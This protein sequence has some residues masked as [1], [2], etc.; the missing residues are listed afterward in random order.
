MLQ[1]LK[2]ADVPPATVSPAATVCEAIEEMVRRRVGAVAVVE[3][4]K[5]AGIFTERDVMIRVVLEGRNPD[6]TPVREVMT[7]SVTTATTEITPG[8][9]LSLMIE[10]HFRHLPI[11]DENGRVAGML[12]IRNVLESRLEDVTRE[13]DSLGIYLTADGPGG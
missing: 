7:A 12:S 9:A 4:D 11:L 10:H 8:E 2:L 1:I 13:L 6:K 5:L 3:S